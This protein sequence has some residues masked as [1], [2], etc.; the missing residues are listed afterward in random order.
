MP[1][2]GNSPSAEEGIRKPSEIIDARAQELSQQVVKT[3]DG[4]VY[5]RSGWDCQFI[6]LKEFL[7][8]RP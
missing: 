4:R 2:A 1:E 6:A 5:Y 3:I 8:S 7:D